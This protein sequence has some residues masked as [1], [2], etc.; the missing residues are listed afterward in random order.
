MKNTKKNVLIIGASGGIGRELVKFFSNENYNL[1][2]HYYSNR[3]ELDSIPDS[4]V[5]QADITSEESVCSMIK[6][7]LNDFEK[8]DVLINAA[9]VSISSISW[10][11]KVAD[12]DKT[13]G[14]N[15]NGPFLC[16]REVLPSMRQN[17]FGRIINLSSVVG[18]IGVVGTVAY[19]ASKSGLF[20]M[21]KTISK[22]IGDKDITINNIALGYFNRGMIEQVPDELKN[23][24]ISSIPIKKLGEVKQLADCIEYL[25]KESSN[26]ITGQT[27][28]LNGGMY[29]N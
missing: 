20:G 21:V 2:C 24:I 5:F 14:I 19:A 4:H 28:N 27:I 16:I 12:W 9:G 13:I 23:E 7:I 18:Q 10:K 8:I 3:K 1:I 25:I 11:T 26:Y 22:E 29:G 6:Q 15:L 17:N